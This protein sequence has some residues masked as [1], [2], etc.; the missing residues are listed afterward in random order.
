[1]YKNKLMLSEQ[2][3]LKAHHLSRFCLYMSSNVYYLMEI[4]AAF[5]M[6][7]PFYVLLAHVLR[8]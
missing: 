5:T 3:E 8:I 7:K 1:M 4:S 2:V 6:T